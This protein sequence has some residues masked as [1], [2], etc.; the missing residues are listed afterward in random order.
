MVVSAIPQLAS[1]RAVGAAPWPR[2]R[3]SRCRPSACGPA[4]RTGLPAWKS[5]GRQ[6][7]AARAPLPLAA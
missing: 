1:S 3:E 4:Y 7:I 5:T 6:P 2:R